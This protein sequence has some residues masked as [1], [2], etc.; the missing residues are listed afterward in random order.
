MERVKH[1]TLFKYQPYPVEW[2]LLNNL[3]Y[4]ANQAI[5]SFY[6]SNIFKCPQFVKHFLFLEF[7]FD[8]NYLYYN[9]IIVLKSYRNYKKLI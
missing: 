4:Q 5:R 3:F 1:Q 2:F 9:Y 6:I 8:I 7:S